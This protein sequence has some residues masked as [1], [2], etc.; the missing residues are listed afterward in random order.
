[1]KVELLDCTTDPLFVI[2][3]AARTCYNSRNKDQ[4]NKRADFVKGLIKSGHCYDGETE[5]LT[6]KGF[7]KWRDYNGE[8][9]A[10]VNKDGTFRAFEFPKSII[11]YQY[12]GIVYDYDELGTIV[13]E[14]HNLYGR[15]I[16]NKKDNLIKNSYEYI[17][18]LFPCNKPNTSKSIAH[19]TTKIETEGERLIRIPSCCYKDDSKSPLGELLGFWVGDGCRGYNSNKLLFHLKLRRK[20]NYLKNLCYL[21]NYKFIEHKNDQYVVEAN[22]DIGRLTNEKYVKDGEKYIP[23]ISDVKFISGIIEGLL[24]SDG[25]TCKDNNHTSFCSTSRFII[26][27]LINYACLAG[28]KVSENKS[29]KRN[30]NRKKLYRVTLTH[31]TKRGCPLLINDTRKKNKV[32]IYDVKKMP[33]FCVQVST[34]II[35]VRGKTGKTFLCGNCTPL[36]FASA[37]F[38]ISGISR[39]CQN[40]I[41]R[42]R[43]ASYCVLSERYVDVSSMDC[44]MPVKALQ[45]DDSCIDFVRKSKEFY[46]KL[47][48]ADVPKEDAR[49]F[50][51]QGMMTNMCMHMNFRSLRHFL[52]LRL[53]RHAQ[54]EIREVAKEIL[55]ICENKWPW[56]I[57]DLENLYA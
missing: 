57:F 30:D 38:D 55:E 15:S 36:E 45:A 44:L 3:M 42:H 8:E 41:V 29:I 25:S 5:V 1:M 51:P 13:T 37:T 23:I 18:R 46:K 53:D 12:D 33:V 16:N 26:D 17:Y 39:V 50:L 2:S 20:I 47:V 52:K 10:V 24:K 48:L 22:F 21:L 56:L 35:I 11:S 43:I 32:K 4:V 19:S 49:M 54:K 7:I 34:G 40:Q 31:F 28:Y 14:G 27:W 9:V 6:K